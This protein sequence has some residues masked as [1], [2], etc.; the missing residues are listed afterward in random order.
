MSRIEDLQ[1]AMVD[2]SDIEV[3]RL[4]VSVIAD[5]LVRLETAET[6]WNSATCNAFDAWR[7]GKKV[8]PPDDFD[9]A[10][11]A[12]DT[13]L[14]A[15]TSPVESDHTR[16]SREQL[17]TT[18]S[19]HSD[20]GRVWLDDTLEMLDEK[21]Q[22]ILEG[23]PGT[24]KTFI[25]RAIAHHLAGREATA[26]VQFHPGTAYEDF[27]QGLRPDPSEPGRFAITD[28]PLIRF[29]EDAGTRPEVPHVLIIDEINRANLPAVFGELYF[30]L[31]YRDEPVTMTYGRQFQLPPN[32]LI[33]GTMNT[34]DRS[35][36]AVDAA[37]RRRFV[38]R[39]VRPGEPPL[40]DIL[41]HWLARYAPTLTWLNDLLLLANQRIRDRD[42]AIGPSHFLRT[43]LTEKHARRAWNHTVLPTL[44]EYFYGQQHRLAELDFDALKSAVTESDADADAD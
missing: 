6:D 13:S 22:M 17:E 24:G 32:L 9:D 43:D 23:P 37:L 27:V 26:L 7:A 39:E 20:A 36:T 18:L 40:D 5:N 2:H 33:I 14:T 10:S 28:G 8:A 3:T 4:Q 34:A 42:Q 16:I 15:P 19:I 12:D 29:A 44:T 21:R 25:A 1:F 30:L 35:I 38:F 31:E 41:P 11:P